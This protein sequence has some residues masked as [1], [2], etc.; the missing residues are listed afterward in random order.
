MTR[1]ARWIGACRSLKL[2]F[3]HEVR[4][5]HAGRAGF[6]NNAGVEGFIATNPAQPELI[7]SLSQDEGETLD[8]EAG[9]EAMSE[10]LKEKGG[11]IYLPAE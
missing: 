10:V 7:L 9:M 11:E 1:Q 3:G 4:Q 5:N 8:A 6:C 2:R